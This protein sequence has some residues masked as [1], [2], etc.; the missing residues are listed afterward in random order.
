MK[1]VLFPVLGA[2]AVFAAG[3]TPSTAG[4]RYAD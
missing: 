2:V 4:D 3:V 1:T